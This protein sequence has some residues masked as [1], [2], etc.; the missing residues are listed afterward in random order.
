MIQ[1]K[2]QNLIFETQMLITKISNLFQ[3]NQYQQEFWGKFNQQ[4]KDF[5]FLFR[6]KEVPKMTIEEEKKIENYDC[7][8]EDSENITKLI[9]NLFQQMKNMKP[10]E[11]SAILSSVN[12]HL[13]N[14]PDEP[15]KIKSFEQCMKIL[16]YSLMV[17]EEETNK[18]FEKQTKE[19]EELHEK[20]QMRR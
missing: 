7:Y 15:Q 13:K 2:Q 6:N 4:I 9:E 8:F 1:N 18:T 12:N 16:N 5:I 14:L 19:K 20:Q 17:L 11:V 10:K 3:G